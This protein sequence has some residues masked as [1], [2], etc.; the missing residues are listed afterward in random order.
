M[1]TRYTDKG[2]KPEVGEYYGFDHVSFIVGNALQAADWYCTRMGFRHFAY[3]GL[4]TGNRDIVCHVIKQ[5]KVFLE[6]KSALQ[7]GNKEFGAHM[8]AH[9]DGAK[10]VAFTVDD[11]RGIYKAAVARGAKSIEE[12]HK[13]EDS[14]GYVWLSS[15]QTYGDT[16]HTFVE[17]KNYKGPYLPGY[18]KLEKKDPVYDITGP[19]GLSYIDH[20]VG[21]Q[22]SDEM[23][24]V[25]EWYQKV[26]QFHRFWSVDDDTL[27][28]EYSALRSIVVTDYHENI[29]MPINEPAPGKK[30]SQIQ[31]YVEFYG[32]AGV[33][34]IAMNT[35][36]IIRAITRMRQRGCEFLEIPDQYY[37][38]LAE[39]LK[40][41]PVNV[42]EDLETLRKLKIL[43][44]YDDNGYLLQLFTK[45]TQDRPTLFYEVIQRCNHQ[46]F[47]AGNFKALFKA[48]ELAQAERG[49]LTN[50]QG[51]RSK[52][53]P[54]E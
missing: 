16:I 42:K 12:P 36:D 30:K 22:A 5:D 29:K 33:Q 19:V 24:P 28:T 14:D 26:L 47:G 52:G 27:R 10:N 2:S 9:G 8:E 6:F 54:I 43:V 45:P 17:R 37:T 40:K 38:Q 41:S 3:K 49:N 15:V 20:V 4:E 31:E 7:P 53:K 32:G 13:E 34:H 25:A 35:P 50:D 44:D 23:T 21:N 11:C 39:R 18:K 51:F 1:G 46:G 48:I